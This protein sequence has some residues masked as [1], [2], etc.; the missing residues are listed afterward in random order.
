MASSTKKNNFYAYIMNFVKVLII[1]KN[2]K[3]FYK[4]YNN[5][6]I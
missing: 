1:L 3:I 5:T 4:N 2:R 6:K